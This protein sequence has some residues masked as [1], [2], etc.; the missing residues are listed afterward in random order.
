LA[1]KKKQAIQ[2]VYKFVQ[3]GTVMNKNLQFVQ[4]EGNVEMWKCE[5]WPRGKIWFHTRHKEK[6]R[7]KDRLCKM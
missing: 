5:N 2:Y 1:I 3:G 7:H 6:W 4:E